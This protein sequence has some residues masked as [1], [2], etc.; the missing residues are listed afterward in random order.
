MSENY[1]TKPG[2]KIPSREDSLPKRF[3]ETVSVEPGEGG[4]AVLLDGRSVKT[5]ARQALALPTRAAAEIIAA[6][7]AAQGERI[8]AP[9]MPATRLVFV[10]LDHMEAAHDA[11]AAEITKYASTDLLCFRAPEP[12][13]LIRAQTSAWDPLLGWAERE[14]GIHLVA[15]AGLM[16]VEQDAVALA[17]VN[18]R[19]ARLDD[20]R[21]TILAHTTS[22]CGSAILGLALLEG[23]ID[24][25]QAFALSTVDEHYQIS[26][27]GEDHEAGQRLERLKTELV[28]ADR[29]LRAFDAPDTV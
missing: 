29:L 17:T 28:A 20:L 13:D 23:E 18:A 5:P 27:W 15:S 14:L 7:W 21:L 26:Q 24:G 11:T 8:D 2:V 3:Y 16:P 19:A 6:E 4:W 1:E 9:N 10:A 25:E 22:V 12:A